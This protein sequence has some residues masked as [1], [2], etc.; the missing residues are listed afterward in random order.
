MW[1]SN[2]GQTFVL[3]GPSTAVALTAVG[4]TLQA[5]TR[6]SGAFARLEIAFF[7]SAGNIG[8]ATFDVIAEFDHQ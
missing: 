7:A 1:V 4:T 2:D 3:Q 5:P 6:V 8:A